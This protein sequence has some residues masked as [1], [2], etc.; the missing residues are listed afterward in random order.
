MVDF[1]ELRASLRA[2]DAAVVQ[3]FYQ[4]S[5]APNPATQAALAKAQQT[6]RASKTALNT[7]LAASIRPGFDSAASLQGNLPIVLFPVR[8]ETRFVRSGGVV[9]GGG[10]VATG[11]IVRSAA[12]TVAPTGLPT[13]GV[14]AAPPAAAPVGVL[15]IRVYPDELLAQTH[16]PEL[17]DDEWQAGRAYWGAGDLLASWT[18]LLA[19]FSAQRAAWI[20]RQTQTATRPPA[21]AASWTRPATAVMPD[22]FAAFAYRGGAL[23]ASAVGSAVMEPLTLTVSP[24]LDSAQR[25]AIPGGTFQVDSDLL[26]TLDFA[27]AKSVGMGLELPL[28]AVDWMQGFGLLVVVGTKGT[29]SIADA[30]QQI[31]SIF[32][33]HH[34]TRGLALVPP[35]TPT[36]NLPD[37]P[38]GFP[39]ADPAGA[40]SFAIERGAP[41][42]GDGLLLAGALGLSAEAVAHVEQTSLQADAAARAMLTALWPATLGY[43]LEQMMAPADPSLPPP[44]DATAVAAAYD[45]TRANVRP[46]G[47]LPAFRVGSVPYA[48]APVTSLTRMARTAPVQ[49][50]SALSALHANLLAASDQ[51]PRIN[52]ASTDPDGDLVNVLRL[53]ASAMAF[54]VQVLIGSQLQTQLGVLPGLSGSLNVSAL[55]LQAGIADAQ[56]RSLGL[57]AASTP[58]IAQASFGTP[59]PFFGVLVSS[60]A[61]HQ[62]PL[63]AGANYIQWILDQLSSGGTA[64]AADALPA[65]YERTLLYQLLR[66]AVLVE[67]GR[68][69]RPNVREVEVLGLATT[70]TAALAPAPPLPSPPV[71]HMADVV[72][73]LQMLSG[74]PIAELERLFT[75]T[76]DLCSHRFDAWITSLATARLKLLRGASAT[77][78]TGVKGS[79][80]GAYGWVQN[81]KPVTNPFDPGPGGFIHAPSPN[82]AQTAAILRNG[83]LARGQAGTHLYA[84]DLSSARVRA[85]LD[86]LARIRDG[87]ALSEILGTE[88]ETRLRADPA[89]A[90]TFLE[91]LRVSYPTPSSPILD[92]LAAVL[93]WRASPTSPHFPSAIFSDTSQLLDSAADLLT[94]ESVF[95]MVR[96][97]PG[98][99][100]AGLDALSQG[101]RPPEPQVAHTPVAGIGLTHRVALVLDDTAAHGWTAPAT[102]RSSACRYVDGW[103]GLLLGDPQR[104]TCRVNAAS[105]PHVVTLAQLGLRPIDVVALSGVALDGASEF[106]KRIREQAGDPSAMISYAADPAWG[107]GAV[108]FPAL[109]EA[110]R[111]ADALISLA[112]PLAASDL[113]TSA[114]T[115]SDLVDADVAARAKAALDAL[116][117]LDLA[118]PATQRAQ[119]RLSALFGF[120][121][122]YVAD[123]APPAELAAV[124][125]RVD[126]ERQNRIREALAVAAPADV[127]RCVF[128]RRLPL[129]GGFAVPATIAPALAGP[130][131]LA[132]TDVSKWMHKAARV[133]PA[134]DRWRRTRLVADALGAPAAAWDVVQ[135]PYSAA[136]RW[137]ALPFS[138]GAGPS[139][140][141]VSITVHRPWEA[142]PAAKWAGLLLD[143][144]SEL[145][146]SP[147]QQ[148]ALAFHYPSPRAEAPQAVLVAIPPVAAATWSTQV[149]VD[150]VRETFELARIRLVTPSALGNLSLLLPATSLSVN[151]AGDTLSTN[152]WTAAIAPIQVVAARG[153]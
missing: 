117:A 126:A 132:A 103:L 153:S 24:A 72:A 152:L 28:F 107:P 8:L 13:T 133:R 58:R 113:A 14:V 149:L 140:G 143:E 109:M 97:N 80:F 101:T 96:G 77:G 82:H 83:F 105:G 119:L 18:A 76:L 35:G 1:T 29:F 33:G 57:P 86:L 40:T 116:A 11:G 148:T 99:A 45:Y 49:L 136:A 67:Q 4:Q 147:I 48:V 44:F 137:C 145:I 70:A 37:A 60:A 32:D 5:L 56:L 23:V 89:L 39:T 31:Q 100:T 110:A 2:T 36:S 42:P 88:I 16:E 124:A 138:S 122:A 78:I 121:G 68:V 34:Y 52:P 10:R 112:R 41:A 98:G 95:Q 115:I 131:G 21:R 108:T 94:A 71:S 17:T 50:S 129:I 27:T 144:W 65:A 63:P 135:L 151:S 30:G 141:T 139:S 85:G 90:T 120:G 134:L 47:P 15:Q 87:E 19:R 12:P 54:L 51:A 114:D 84:L 74:L 26:W 3:A 43:H 150:I 6:A 127:I 93:A 69:A 7:A 59:E 118:T 53:D 9:S 104:V 130:A 142:A 73:A 125:K 146:P 66:H 128:G 46:G 55:G 20:V 75:E 92:G 79:H 62:A 22:N 25:V 123:N 61:E 111:A 64:L 91:P 38:S 81:V 102:P 106:D